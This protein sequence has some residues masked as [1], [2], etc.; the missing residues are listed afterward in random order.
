MRRAPRAPRR[1]RCRRARCGPRARRARWRRLRA[2]R[3]SG[4]R[5]REPAIVACQSRSCRSARALRRGCR[6]PC[7]ATPRRRRGVATGAAGAA[8]PRRRI[9]AGL[10][11]RDLSRRNAEIGRQERGRSS[12]LVTITRAASAS[13]ARSDARALRLPL[14]GK[15]G[16]RPSGWCTSAT[17]GRREARDD[18]SPAWRRRRARRS[19]GRRRAAPADE[20]ARGLGKVALASGRESRRAGADGGRQRPAPAS[21]SRSR[22][23]IG[24]AAGRRWQGRRERRRRPRSSTGALSYQARA[25]SDSC[26]VTRMRATPSEPGPSA[27]C[28]R[29]V[30]HGVEDVL[31]QEF[32]RRVAAGEYAAASS[33]FW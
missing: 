22:A 32:G 1:R 26:R 33:R 23:G 21:C 12:G 6:S 16:S 7:A 5:S 18:R 15:A 14:R 10:G 25:T 31:R 2:A 30:G 19:G 17:I 13:A 28:A 4:S 27:P 8:G 11:D 29:R 3:R 24:I 20:P 9:G